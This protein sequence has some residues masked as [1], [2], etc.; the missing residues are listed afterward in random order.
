MGGRH[1]QHQALIAIGKVHEDFERAASIARAVYDA[2]LQALR[3]GRT[4]GD[5]VVDMRKPLEN[6]GGLECGPAVHG[7]NPPVALSGFPGEM[8]GAPGAEGCPPVEDTPTLLADMVLEPGMCFSFEPTYVFGRSL[9]RLGG[10]VIVGDDEPV[11][12]SPYT[13][14]ILHATGSKASKPGNGAWSLF[15]L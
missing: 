1:T 9:V 6:A 10:T 4:F 7:L 15:D 14:K 3:P 2:G 13:A 12:L 5:F 11:E 8:R